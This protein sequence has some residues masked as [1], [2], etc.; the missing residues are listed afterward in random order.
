MSQ[1][2]HSVLRTF[3]FAQDNQPRHLDA[4]PVD[5]VLADDR[6]VE[7][8]PH[9]GNARSDPRARRRRLTMA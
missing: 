6:I 5:V 8:E 7:L 3:L 9:R 1:P 4:V 2:L